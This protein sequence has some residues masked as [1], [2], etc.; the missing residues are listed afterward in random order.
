MNALHEKLDGKE[1]EK[2]AI[3]L[4]KARH[5]ASL[6]IRVVKTVKSADGRVLR[7]PVEVREGWEEYFKELLNKEFP[8]WEAG[9]EQPTEGPI[10]PWMQEEVRKAIGKT[11]LGKAAEPDGVPVEAW[12][13]L[14]NLG[15]NWWLTQFLKRI[16]KEG[17]MPDEWRNSTIVPVFKQK[18]DAS[19]CSN[20]R[21]IKLISHT[22]KIYKRLVDS[23]LREMVP[24][25]V[26]Y[27]F[28]P[29]RSTTGAIFITR[30]VMEK[31]REKRRPCYLAFLDVEKAYDRLARAVIRNALRGR[32]A[33][34]RLITV[35]R[36]MY[37]GS[38]A[39]IRT[40]H[41]V[42]RKVDI[43]VGYTKVNQLEEGPLRTI[44]YADDIA[45]VADNQE[46]LEEKVQLWQ[47]ALA[48]DG[49]RLNVKKTKFISSEQCAGSILDCQAE[50]IKKV[51][52]FRYFGSDRK[53]GPG[54]QGTDKRSLAQVEGVHRDPL[55]P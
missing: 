33:P 19:E 37:E 32:G 24:S 15:I 13:V 23:T 36:D 41:G 18:G 39:A 21:G 55:L 25:H 53:C 49:L 27:G 50:T 47:R 29:E 5:R 35:I 20:Y 48:D 51:E 8:R 28:M 3:R 40:P 38:K 16:T 26:Q 22:M 31:Y 12:K 2:F 10:T 52:E 46:Q 54:C 42:T 44:L 17:K 4:A 43:T 11:K 1:G 7:K 34:E 14:G 45:L 30:Q 6:D 9:E